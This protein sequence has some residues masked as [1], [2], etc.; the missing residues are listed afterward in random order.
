MD[1]RQK[2]KSLYTFLRDFTRLRSKIITDY[3]KH[4]WVGLI[5]DIHD[6]Y[7]DIS[8]FYRDKIEEDSSDD[9]LTILKIHRPHYTEKCPSPY[10]SFKGW[11]LPGWEDFNKNASVEDRKETKPATEGSDAEYEQFEDDDNRVQD[12][13][14]WLEERKK[15]TDRQLKIKYTIDLFLE[16]Y[17]CHVDLERESET[18]EMVVASGRLEDK[19]NKSINHPVLTK[20]VKTEYN[21]AT[22]TIRI[23]DTD[24][25]PEL[26]SGVLQSLQDVQTECIKNLSQELA[27]K[28]YHPL[29]RHDTPDYLKILARSLSKD[30]VFVDDKAPVND[31]GRIFIHYQP[32]FIIRKRTDGAIKAL[33][34]IVDDI[35]EAEYLPVPL[36]EIVGGGT[37]DIPDDKD[38][39]IEERLAAVGGEDVDILLSKEANREQLEIARRVERYNAVLVQGPPGTGKT[40]TIANLMGHFLAQGKSVLVTSHTMKALSVLKEKVEPGIRDL[41][42]SILDDSNK[43]MER[44]VDGITDAMGRMT[45]MGLKKEIDTIKSERES[46]IEQLGETRRKLYSIINS[47]KQSLAYDGEGV[48]P[49]EAASFIYQNRDKLAYIPGKVEINAPLPLSIEELS[50][51][52]K[53]NTEIC[54]KD[55]KELSIGLPNPADIP[56]IESARKLFQNEAT[57]H[58]TIDGIVKRNGWKLEQGNEGYAYCL[59]NNIRVKNVNS[60][61]L[62]ELSEYL[63]EFKSVEE[64][65]KAVIIDGKRGG[66]YEKRWKTLKEEIDICCKTTEEYIGLSLGKKIGV[67]KEFVNDELVSKLDTIIEILEKKGKVTKTSLLLKPSVDAVMKAVTINGKPI[68][69]KD[70]ACCV[71]QYYLAKIARENAGRVWNELMIPHGLDEFEMLDYESPEVYAKKRLS[72]L[73]SMLRW[74]GDKYVH[75]KGLVEEAGLDLQEIANIKDEDT[76]NEE[77]D[78]V[79][80][81]IGKELP[82]IADVLLACEQLKN[83][84]NIIESYITI[85]KSGQ[86]EGLKTCISVVNALEQ[87]D[88]SAYGSAY[89]TLKMQYSKNDLQFKRGEYLERI[90]RVAPKWAEAIMSRDGIH[91]KG[92]LPED[93]KGAWKWKQYVEMLDDLTNESYSELQSKSL[94][95][96]KEYRRITALY[97]EKLAWYHLLKETEADI[98]MKQALVGWKLTVKKIGKGTG[99]NAPMYRRQARGLMA[100]CQKAVPAWIMTINKALESLDPHTNKFDVVIVDEASQSDISALA[101]LYMAKKVIIVGD[102]KQVSPLAVGVNMDDINAL[103]DMHLTGIIANSHLYTAKTSLYDIAATTFQPLMLREHFRCVPEI[104]GFSNGLSYDFKIK[105]LRDESDSKLLPAVV[106]FRVPNG[107]R[108]DNKINKKEAKTIIA[109]MKACIEQP[110]YKDKSFG[111][112]S[113]LGDEQAKHIRSLIARYIDPIENENRR[114]LCGNASNFQGDERDVVFLSIVDSN[115]GDG[116]LRNQGSGVEDAAQKRYNVAASRARDQLWVVNSLDSGNDLK[117]GDLR[118]RLIDYAINPAAFAEKLQRI[119]AESESPFEEEVAKSLVARGYDIVQQWKVGSY[120]ID[121]VAI[122]KNLKIAIECDGEAYHSSDEQIRADMERQ[123]ILERCGWRFLRIRGSEYFRDP[124]KIIEAVVEELNRY[125]IMPQSPKMDEEPERDSEL[126]QRVKSRAA[127]ILEE[128]EKEDGP[129]KVDIETIASALSSTPVSEF[130]P[131]SPINSSRDSI[132]E[133]IKTAEHREKKSESQE[134]IHQ[135]QNIVMKGSSSTK[136]PIET[137]EEKPSRTVGVAEVYRRIAD[138]SE[139]KG[140]G[141]AFNITNDLSNAGLKYVDKSVRRVLWVIY[142]ENKIEIA[143]QIF[144]KYNCRY[145]LEERGTLATGGIKAWRVVIPL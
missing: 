144:E 95:L 57:L 72:K 138:N 119:V 3:K 49:S 91:G 8:L 40:H 121:M 117:E 83:N 4:E 21:A 76:D 56:D 17:Q 124:Q 81:V 104:I 118:K 125:G 131:G 99:K 137:K 62:Q 126:L 114:I 96:S 6:E 116:P 142:D 31:D 123:T 30:G 52:Y 136:A 128:M 20:R 113:M 47:E 89:E 65:V 58:K 106:N 130:E 53:S 14:R 135:K 132:P 36:T 87:R 2:L 140:R 92:V 29:D 120:R 78:K 108:S 5:S 68:N 75:L 15:W 64:W 63:A 13:K 112:I 79:L 133:P 50:E 51:L 103:T 122:Y 11:L 66:A 115:E 25:S 86:R 85:L 84:D 16:I 101:I 32:M 67:P 73:D 93:I 18:L 145:S 107:Y 61:N 46:V 97:A 129:K 12:Y 48:S 41:C 23:I 39:T 60:E 94:N 69:S 26:Y 134:D 7:D 9:D 102:D 27:E 19:K 139:S 37:I 1:D 88:S 109:L 82:D 38:E 90:A 24:V 28:E 71:K 100:K 43:D 54:E 22:D 10:S 127:E 34:A 77:L 111:I 59:S 45:S 42:V 110:E 33:E 80:S 44:S 74:Y 141:V 98:D 105:P 70:D 35:D 55:E 143:Q